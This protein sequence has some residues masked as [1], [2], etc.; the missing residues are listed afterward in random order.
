MNDNWSTP[1]PTGMRE[2][3]AYQ[4]KL[5]LAHKLQQ[6]YPHAYFQL[7]QPFCNTAAGNDAAPAI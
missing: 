6:A 5:R 2:E 3:M 1:V 7:L 4:A